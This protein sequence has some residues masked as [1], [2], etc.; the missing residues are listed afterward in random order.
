[1][2]QNMTYRDF[3]LLSKQ[4]GKQ[5]QEFSTKI[6][7]YY[8]SKADYEMGMQIENRKSCLFHKNFSDRRYKSVRRALYRKMIRN[9]VY[10][11]ILLVTRI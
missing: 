3:H 10:T 4:L 11:Y 6:G 1:M 9:D 5:R 8:V 7:A 2:N